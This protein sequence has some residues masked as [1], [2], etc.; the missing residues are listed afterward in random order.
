MIQQNPP[1]NLEESDT[2]DPCKKKLSPAYI[3]GVRIID[4]AVAVLKEFC[5]EG[6]FV[7]HSR[8]ETIQNN[9]NFEK[10]A[11]RHTC[12]LDFR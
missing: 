5:K 2:W 12:F 8:I 3:T 1:E 6:K 4:V 7:I 9:T 10:T 11:G